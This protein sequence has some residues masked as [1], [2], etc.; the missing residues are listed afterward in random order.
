MDI[1]IQWRGVLIHNQRSESDGVRRDVVDAHALSS[2][3]QPLQ[4]LH[5]YGLLGIQIYR[6]AV[7]DHPV[8]DSEKE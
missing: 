1:W 4:N 5:G 7:H 6:K 3:L 2:P 8:S